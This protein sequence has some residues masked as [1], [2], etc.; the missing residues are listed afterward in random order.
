MGWG[1]AVRIEL[2]DAERSELQARV[3]R[4]KIA[5]ADAMRAAIVLL[6]ADGDVDARRRPRPTSGG[7]GRRPPAA[8]PRHLP[9]ACPHQ[10]RSPPALAGMARTG[11]AGNGVRDPEAGCEDRFIPRAA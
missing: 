10:R 5:R 7:H 9:R 11:V 4:R 2:T 1:A 6:A 3:R 8:D